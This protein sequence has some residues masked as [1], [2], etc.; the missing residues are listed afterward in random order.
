MT[1]SRRKLLAGS[2]IF[3]A[4]APLSA[5][6]TILYP[7]RKGQI[8]GRIDPNVAILN[9][10]G[11][12]LFLVPGVI[13]FAVDFSNGTIYLPGTQ[14]RRAETPE[15]KQVAYQG[16]LTRKRLDD[17]WQETYGHPAPFELRELE[18][19]QMSGE[20]ELLRELGAHPAAAG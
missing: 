8:D 18:R 10:I 17:A 16:N 9:G 15:V 11:L 3:L 14:T 7:E 12:L 1:L 19:R 20:A 4:A 13:A 6:G 2:G 5:C